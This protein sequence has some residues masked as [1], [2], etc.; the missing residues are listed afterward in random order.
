LINSTPYVVYGNSLKVYPPFPAQGSFINNIVVRCTLVDN[1]VGA[2]PDILEIIPITSAF[3]SN[4]NFGNFN[5][6]FVKL[7]SGQYKNFT[8]SLCD[9]NFNPIQIQDPNMLL[10][11][12][13]ELGTNV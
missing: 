10:E 4:I 6:T 11:L 2:I 13:I 5:Q 1:F 3:G 8:I 7:K 9:Q 12:I